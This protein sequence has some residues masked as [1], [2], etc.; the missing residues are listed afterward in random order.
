[1]KAF[2]VELALAGAPDRIKATLPFGNRFSDLARKIC[3]KFDA[4][5]TP[6]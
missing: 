4:A 5:L 6:S 3:R 2:F 1:M